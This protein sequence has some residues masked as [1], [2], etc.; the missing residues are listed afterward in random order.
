M[1]KKMFLSFDL[2][3]QVNIW[4]KFSSENG[5]NEYIYENDET[6]INSVYQGETYKL[7]YHIHYGEYDYNDSY[8]YYDDLGHLVSFSDVDFLHDII[9]VDEM[10]TWYE[11]TFEGE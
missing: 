4:N 10:I 8:F 3:A 11:N 7:A 5:W 9:D 6:T 2:E 1:T